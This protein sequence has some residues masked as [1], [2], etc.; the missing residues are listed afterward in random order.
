MCFIYCRLPAT[1]KTIK[2]ISADVTLIF[3]C[4]LVN[5]EL[6]LAMD[7]IYINGHNPGP[8]FSYAQI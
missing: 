7:R 6:S 4:S 1:E 2:T 8:K 3:F 5:Y